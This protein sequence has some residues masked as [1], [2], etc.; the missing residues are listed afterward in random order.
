MHGVPGGQSTDH[1]S[2]T[3][4]KNE[5][6]TNSSYEQITVDLWKA[7]ANRYKD[8][9]TVAAYDLLNEPQ[10]N[11]GT[12]TN[13][14]GAGSTRAVYETVRV[15]DRLYR[16]IRSVDSNTIIMME[17]IW[18]MN[19][20]APSYVHNGG[21]NQNQ[22]HSGKTVIWDNVM[23]S[24]NIYDSEQG[25]ISYRAN[26]LVN[27]RRD[28]KAA[29]H[30]GEFNNGDDNQSW[31]YTQYNNNRINWNA[32]TYKLAGA[33]YGNWSVY[34]ASGKSSVNARNDSIDTIKTKWG[35]TL[36]TFSTGTNNLANGFNQQ[37][38]YNFFTT[39]IGQT[40][41]GVFTNSNQSGFPVGGTLGKIPAP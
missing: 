1:C 36:R 13:T 5:L 4:H 12:G 19:L 32:W 2:G 39:G 14:W 11:G 16:E 8:E 38:A 27:M 41:N 40:V 35:T 34:Q 24:M 30:I 6:W 9:A 31:A 25:M 15:Y 3:L 21:L 28:G 22:Q 29:A 7:I 10:N 26:E 20:P 37:G 17:G 18:S 23:Y 33:N